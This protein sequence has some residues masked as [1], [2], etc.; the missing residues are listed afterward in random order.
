MIMKNTKVKRTVLISVLILLLAGLTELSAQALQHTPSDFRGDPNLRRNSNM[1]GNN[2]RATIFNTGYSGKPDNRPDYIAYEW[3][4]N[5]NRIYIS[6]LAIWLGGEVKDNNGNIIHLIDMPVWRTDQNGNSWNME[7][8][9][10]FSNPMS[11]E[12]ARSDDESSWPTKAQGGWRDKR[13][14]VLDPGW[15]GSWNGFFGKNIFNA[16]QEFYFIASDNK[17]D[18]FDYTPDTT[19]PGRAGLGLLMDVRTL[20]WT[21]VLINDVVFLIHDIKNDG[22]KVIDKASF[23]IFLADYVGGDGTD[24]YP[25]VDLQTDIAFLTDNDRIGTEPFG[26]DPVGV[27]SIKYIETPGNQVDGIDNDG[28]CDV[29]S[30]LQAAIGGDVEQR[31]PHFTEAD[32][33]ARNLT[34]GN[35]IVLIE[36]VTFNRIITTYPV[37]GGTVQSLGRVYNLPPAGVTLLEDSVAN[38]YDDDLDGLI[39]ENRN[40]HLFRYDE[41]SRTEKPVR[42]INYNF[43]AAGDTVKRGFVA[44]G[45]SLTAAYDNIAPMIDESR[46]DNFDNDKDWDAFYDDLGLDGVRNSGDPGE[47]DGKP[48]SGTG[49]NFPGEPNIDKT[50]VSETDL[51]GITSAVQIPVGQVNFNTAPDN[52]LWDNYLAPGKISLVRQIG[53][54]DTFVSSGF[55][56]ILPGERQRMAIAVAIAGGGISVNADMTSAREKLRQSEL[57]YG[58]D[59]QFAQAPLQVTV[60]AVPGD[61]KVTLY[62]DDLAEFSF[63]RYINKIGGNPKDFEGYRIYRATDAAFLDAKVI[64]DA[65]GVKTLMKPIAQFDL[66]DGVKGLHPV[67]INGVKFDLGNDLGIEHQ[68]TD[69]DVING[70]TYYYA[71]TAYDFGYIAGNIPPTETPVRIDV[72][73]TGAVKKSSNVVIVR[74]TNTASGYVPP[75]VESFVHSSG[76]ASGKAWIDIIDPEALREGDTYEITFRDTTIRLADGTDIVTTKSY[77]LDNMTSGARLIDKDTNIANNRQ[78]LT[79]QGFRIGFENEPKVEIDQQKTGWNKA[80][81]YS[82]DFDKVIFLNI[83]GVQKPNDYLLIFD[84]PGYGASHDTSLGFIPLPSKQ[85]N[86]KVFNKTENRFIKFAFSEIDGTDGKFSINPSNSNLADAIY[87]L[88]DDGT[89]KLIFTWQIVLNKTRGNRNPDSGDSLRITLKKPFLSSDKYTFSMKRSRISNTL[90]KENLKNIRVVPNPYVAAEI[91]E[92]RNTYTS[93]RGPREIHFINLPAECTVRI[94][95]VSG[96]LINTIEHSASNENGTAVWDVLSSEK[97]EIAYGVYIYHITAPGIG[98]TKG[99]FAIIK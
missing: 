10:G 86:F 66:S 34:P 27:A 91:W 72:D 14:D 1:D 52:Y 17:Y 78:R 31:I 35:K 43:F 70:Q 97:Y 37:G 30:N 23:L 90:A 69:Y 33:P 6:I 7:P 24:D 95:N 92:P 36:P 3:P 94:Y 89:G 19:D 22:T 46:D 74:P 55:F 11:K 88:E 12:I 26:R 82:F 65:Y 77:S 25:F 75:E 18:K 21:Q 29:Y 83:S 62:W 39:D 20:A 67:D 50:D 99:T 63:D 28:D 98:E 56:P 79:T 44:A 8:V 68:Y 93:G 15:A 4:K 13:S 71:V 16:D 47:G 49:T 57:A 38:S 96:V 54:Y 87:F 40:L 81:V 53:E 60:K 64:T 48:S 76:G 5:T 85:V 58:A 59:Y 9:P 32:F 80:E 42:Y 61:G 84:Q 41:V 2:I 45:K 51:I 73:N